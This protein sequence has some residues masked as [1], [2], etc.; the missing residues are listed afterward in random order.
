MVGPSPAISLAALPPQHVQHAEHAEHAEGVAEGHAKVATWALGPGQSPTWAGTAGTAACPD[1]HNQDADQDSEGMIPATAQLCPRRGVSALQEIESGCP[2]PGFLP[3]ALA[4]WAKC[5][6]P[7]ARDM[8]LE[9]ALG[10]F[11]ARPSDRN[12]AVDLLRRCS[13]LV[14]TLILIKSG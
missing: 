4:V 7:A 9:A 6:S 3:K 2:V 10:P 1:K 12:Q 8:Q 13:H 5:Q 11:R 14:D